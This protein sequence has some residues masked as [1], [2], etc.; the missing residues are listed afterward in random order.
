MKFINL[1]EK[2]SGEYIAHPKSIRDVNH[3]LKE[4]GVK[5]KLA[6]GKGYYYFYDGD[7]QYWPD[8]AVYVYRVGDLTYTEWWNEYE[9]LK[10]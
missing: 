7:T 1:F 3:M 2:F 6:K 8:T 5:E 4:K 9:S 10:Q